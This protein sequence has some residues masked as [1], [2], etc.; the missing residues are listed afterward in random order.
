M[1]DGI[2]TGRRG[3]WI[4][5]LLF[6]L[7]LAFAWV[8]FL[9]SD[10]VTYARGAYGW[11]EHFPYVGGH[12]TIRYPITIPMALS[13]ICGLRRWDHRRLRQ[14]QVSNRQP[15]ARRP[16][17]QGVSATILAVSRYLADT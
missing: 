2:Q 9:A 4:G 6:A 15:I 3:L 13:L 17:R 7:L 5:L 1:L 14:G 10:D 8:G 16:L 12:G 11:M